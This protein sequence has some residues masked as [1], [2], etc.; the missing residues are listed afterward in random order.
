MSLTSSDNKFYSWLDDRV[1]VSGFIKAAEKKEV[2]VHKQ[3]MWYYM[4]GIAMVLLAIQGLTGILLMVYYVPEISSAHSSVLFINTQIEFGWFVRSLHSWAAN[5]LIFILFVH[6]FSAYFMKAYR[7]P[8]EVTWFSGMALLGICFAFGFTGY[9]LPWDEIAFFATKIGL[10]IAG[11]TP[12]IGGVIADLLRGG[13]EIGQGT[14]SRFF[15]IHVILLPIAL[16][17][18]AGL[19]LLL[20][21]LHGMSE[22]ESFK[23]AKKKK[24]E[25]FFPDFLVK[26][27]MVWLF[28]FNL[29]AGIVALF[30]WGLGPE[31]DPFA[32]APAGI[33]PEWYFLAMFQ[34]L[35][36]LP[37]HIGPFEGEILGIAFFGVLALV[38]FVAPFID[39]GKSKA[40]SKFFDVYGILFTI[41]FVGFTVWGMLD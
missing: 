37:P 34:F 26:D 35:K 23:K 41:G 2:P 7:K 6:M 17:A 28:F 27:F 5:I 18:V 29:V 36:L 19:H 22:P 13:A 33:K 30:P 1:G 21:Q 31:A 14:I 39:T 15:L 16:F 8:R 20:V 32:P 38:L 25:K 3:S 40:V 12:F 11:K 24:Y 9:L 4:G 10:D